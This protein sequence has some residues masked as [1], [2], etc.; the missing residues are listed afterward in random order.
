MRAGKFAP[1]E[2]GCLREFGKGLRG[3]Q[4]VAGRG[5]LWADQSGEGAGTRLVTKSKSNPLDLACLAPQICAS[6]FAGTDPM[7]HTGMAK[8]WRGIR[9]ICCS[10]SNPV[11]DR[12]LAG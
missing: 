10:Y 7:T 12:G 3:G 5:D 11:L 9:G 2:G 8:A 1:A 4:I 6:G